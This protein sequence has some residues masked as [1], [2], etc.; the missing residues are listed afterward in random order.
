[1]L[2]VLGGTEWVH[3]EG[4]L[5]RPWSDLCTH[6]V[7]GWSL[8]L[9]V[10]MEGH[11]AACQSLLFWPAWRGSE[12]LCWAWLFLR[13]TGRN[14]SALLLR[15]HPALWHIVKWALVD[16]LLWSCFPPD[17]ILLG[18]QGW[19]QIYSDLPASAAWELGLQARAITSGFGFF[20]CYFQVSKSRLAEEAVKCLPLKINQLQGKVIVLRD[21]GMRLTTCLPQ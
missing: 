20:G 18:S 5:L 7:R 21:W 15:I 17:S 19:P 10:G 3:S 11:R 4:A 16:V 1:M 13:D 12:L 14:P 2:F 8:V 6:S 9:P